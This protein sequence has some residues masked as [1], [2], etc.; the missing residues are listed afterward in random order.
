MNGWLDVVGVVVPLVAGVLAWVSHSIR[1]Q[2]DLLHARIR[3]RD[4]RLDRHRDEIA[5]LK[6]SLAV[7][8]VKDAHRSNP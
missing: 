2:I 4:L 5:E 6:T 8:E 1:R 3:E 7:M